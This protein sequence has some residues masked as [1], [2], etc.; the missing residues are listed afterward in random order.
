M[1]SGNRGLLE[2]SSIQQARPLP[3]RVCS[4]IG[5]L[6]AAPLA[7]RTTLVSSDVIVMTDASGRYSAGVPGGFYDVFVSAM[8]FTPTAAKVRVKKEQRITYNST[9]RSDPLVTRDLAHRNE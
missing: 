7:H 5:T 4:F 3:M 6:P 8:A 2:K 9:L 1:L